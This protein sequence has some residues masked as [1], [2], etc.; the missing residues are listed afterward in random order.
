[1]ARIA[2]VVI[3]NIP[4]HIIQRGNRRMEMFFCDEDYKN[5]IEMMSCTCKTVGTE[6]RAYCLMPNH[7]YF[8]M[9][10]PHEWTAAE[11]MN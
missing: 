10:P 1:M 6:V 5:Y 4:H 11:G 8:V 7:V 2:R 9:V 3:P